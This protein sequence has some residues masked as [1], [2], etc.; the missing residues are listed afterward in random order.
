VIHLYRGAEEEGE[1]WKEV[2]EQKEQDTGGRRGG[3]ID[4][5]EI[6][7]WTDKDVKMNTSTTTTTTRSSN[8]RSRT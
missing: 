1:S 6:G 7:Q 3:K 2:A 5:I 4:L 8:G